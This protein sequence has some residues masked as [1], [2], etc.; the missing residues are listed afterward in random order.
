MDK[1]ILFQ[2]NASVL[3]ANGEQIGSLGR[4][5]LNPQT[6]VVTDIVILTGA[7][8]SKE[9][10]VVPVDL[11]AETTEHR[12]LLR[13]EAGNLDDFPP[14]E[15]RFLVD[16]NKDT[17]QEPVNAPQV[18]YGSPGFGPMVVPAPGEEFVTEI[19]QNIPEGTVAMKEGAK[20]ITAEG[21]HVGNVERVLADP[22]VDQVTHLVVSH[23][24]F[25]KESKLIPITWVMSLGEDSVHLRVK[26][27]SVEELDTIPMAG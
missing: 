18:I 26:K 2:K 12:I 21:T 16:A 3:A 15:E 8:F 6:K 7:L 20:V 22:S 24:L 17:D 11:V 9:A 10:R 27:A 13:T 14:F 5:V 19:Q 25:V 1:K 23:G 4:V